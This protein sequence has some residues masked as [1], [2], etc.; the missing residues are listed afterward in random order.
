MNSAA[1]E[2]MLRWLIAA[3]SL[4]GVFVILRLI[5][6]NAV[7]GDEFLSF[8][9]SAPHWDSLPVVIRNIHA[10]ADHSYVHA[11]ILYGAFSLF[12]HDLIVQRLVSLI[13]WASGLAVLYLVL[14]KG[15]H[16]R[17][18]LLFALF[19]TAFSNF[20]IYLATDGRFYSILFFIA[21][22]QL[23]VYTYRSSFSYPVYGI[24]LF[25]VQ[26]TGLLTSSNFIV[27]Q[28]IFLPSMLLNRLI[29]QQR[30]ENR[31]ILT[32]AAATLLSS[33]LY[34]TCFR[35]NYFHHFFLQN[36]FTAKPVANHLLA[37]FISTPFRWFMVPH[38]PFLP[39]PLD[40][41]AFCG[42][43]AIL[44]VIKRKELGTIFQEF[45]DQYRLIN[46]MASVLL[47]LM[48]VQL[49]L[50]WTVGFPLWT[51]RYYTGVFIVVTIVIA[52][53][54]FHLLN[55]RVLAVLIVLMCFRLPAVEYPKIEARRQVQEAVAE[56]DRQLTSQPGMI[57]FT[58]TETDYSAFPRMAHIYISQP[59]VR[60]RLM[61]DYNEADTERMYY[62]LK[63]E[64]L[65]YPLQL[66]H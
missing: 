66:R 23:A 61:L 11:S 22:L 32:T 42:F 3:V 40:V 64:K 48:P 15:D 58:E 41:L 53:L 29:L 33:L 28:C 18:W 9:H 57:V 38:I 5:A 25:L 35:I 46:M 34:F 30:Y 2:K 10:G 52:G 12:G 45:A 13:F 65:G 51:T 37:E 50:M 31:L 19:F 54:L 24:L 36:L 27:L 1:T 56:Q 8:L 63:L 44:L 7:R 21:T 4:F 26:L 14:R 20:G 55:I 60:P 16:Q 47:T 17:L 49:V 39:D 59:E 6:V 43:T 62:F